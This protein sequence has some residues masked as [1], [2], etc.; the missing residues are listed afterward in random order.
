M[1]KYENTANIGDNIMA[2]DFQPMAGRNPDYVEG[3]VVEIT[4]ERGYKA[5][6]IICTLDV[7]NGK[8]L[9]DNGSRIHTFVYVPMETSH[10]YDGRIVKL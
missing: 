3:T 2:Y 9:N 1:L 7:W 5:F 10:D 4:S 6:K 8:V